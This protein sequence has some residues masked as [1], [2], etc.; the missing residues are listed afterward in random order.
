MDIFKYKGY[1]RM[2]SDY[3]DAPEMIDT[4]VKN[5]GLSRADFDNNF[6]FR[7]EWKSK[8]LPFTFPSS[9]K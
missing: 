1:A 3:F 8:Y 7:I 5:S 2:E 4:Y 9:N 6:I